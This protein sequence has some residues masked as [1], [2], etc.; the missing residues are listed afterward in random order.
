MGSN[1]TSTALAEHVSGSEMEFAKLMNLTAKKLGMENSSFLNAHGMTQTEHLSTPRDMAIALRA[2]FDDF[3]E[4]YNLFSRR[5]ADAGFKKVTHS[6]ARFLVNYR[7]ADAFRHGYTKASGFSGA[8][9]AE[10]GGT[11]IITVLFGGR[12]TATR[13]KAIAQLMDMG[14]KFMIQR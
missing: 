12:S 7:G 13:N 1:D 8:A 11:R 14:F 2:I 4:Y 10:R 9:S 5:T 3:P 6:G